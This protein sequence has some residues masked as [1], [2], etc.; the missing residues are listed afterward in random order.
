MSKKIPPGE[1]P[2][3]TWRNAGLLLGKNSSFMVAEDKGRRIVAMLGQP[4][5][6]TGS[7]LWIAMLAEGSR[8]ELAVSRHYEPA[9]TSVSTCKKPGCTRY[10]LTETHLTRQIGAGDWTN[11][12]TDTDQRAQRNL[13]GPLGMLRSIQD[14]KE[15][16]RDFLWCHAVR[17]A[18]FDAIRTQFDEHDIVASVWRAFAAGRR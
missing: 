16:G 3:E 14:H 10:I 5:Q 9:E 6:G 13:G 15:A 1:I 12:I 18:K 8:R 4:K 17:Q 11:R 2:A 7:S